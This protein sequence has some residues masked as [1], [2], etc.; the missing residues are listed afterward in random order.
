MDEVFDLKSRN[1]WLRRRIVAF[2]REILK[3]MLGDTIN[4]RIVDYVAYLTSPDRASG[5]LRNLQCVIYQS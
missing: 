3:A 1:Q 4:R 2:V 5:Y